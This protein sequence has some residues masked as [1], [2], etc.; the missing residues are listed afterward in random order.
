MN[1]KMLSQMCF[2]FDQ[3]KILLSGNGLKKRKLSNSLNMSHLSAFNQNILCISSKKKNFIAH[4]FYESQ[5]C[6]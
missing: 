4:E 1:L 3:S 5:S 2:N 6:P